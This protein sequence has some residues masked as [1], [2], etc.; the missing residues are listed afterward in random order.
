MGG[1]SGIVSPIPRPD[2]DPRLSQNPRRPHGK[3]VAPRLLLWIQPALSNRPLPHQFFARDESLLADTSSHL[4]GW[5][6]LM[7][8]FD[9]IRASVLR[10]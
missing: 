10:L 8:D 4:L 6:H 7:M 1:K 3:P 2:P 9:A 5:W